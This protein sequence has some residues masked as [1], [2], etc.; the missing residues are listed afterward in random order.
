MAQKPVGNNLA[1]GSSPAGSRF[2]ICQAGFG[3]V[4]PSLSKLQK[5]RGRCHT[6]GLLD[7]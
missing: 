3:R 5:P 1:N 6:A 7:A 4:S 2:S